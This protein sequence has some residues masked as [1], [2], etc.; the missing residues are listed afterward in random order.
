[1]PVKSVWITGF[2]GAVVSV[3][4]F[5]SEGTEVFGVSA[6]SVAFAVTLPSGKGFVGVM[7]AWPLSFAVPSPILLPSLSN[8]STLDFGSAWTVTGSFLP[9]LPV[10]SVWIT[11]FAGAVVSV[12]FFGSEG[13]EKSSG[14]WLSTLNVAIAITLPS[15]IGLVGVMVAFP[16]SSATAFPIKLL[17]LLNK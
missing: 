2:A 9:A 12:A 13:I 14:C 10:K 16:L 8:S 1:M 7:T 5:G 11:G 6:L 17:S 4:F 15:G 3:A